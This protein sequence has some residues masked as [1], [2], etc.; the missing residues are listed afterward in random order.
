MER[1]ARI[2]AKVAARATQ[3]CPPLHHPVFLNRFA[4]NMVEPKSPPLKL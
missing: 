3:T 1:P 2:L 4:F